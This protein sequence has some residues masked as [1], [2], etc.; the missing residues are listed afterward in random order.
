MTWKQYLHQARLIRAMA[1]LAG[2]DRGVLSIAADVGFESASGFTRALLRAD[3][4]DA[5]RL[6]PSHVSAAGGLTA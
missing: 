2:S 3:R 4:R 1:L 6:S 5:V